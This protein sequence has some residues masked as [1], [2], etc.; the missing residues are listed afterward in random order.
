MVVDEFFVPSTS[1]P[2]TDRKTLT[3][4]RK[5]LPPDAPIPKQNPAYLPKESRVKSEE[6]PKEPKES[7][8]D[9]PKKGKIAQPTSKSKNKKK[10][11]SISPPKAQEP[12]SSST[13]KPK[14]Q[15]LKK[16]GTSQI[17]T[18]TESDDTVLESYAKSEMVEAM[19]GLD[20]LQLTKYF[21][22]VMSPTM[23]TAT[24][25]TPMISKHYSTKKVND[26]PASTLAEDPKRGEN[27]STWKSKCK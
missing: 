26:I 20:K 21:K 16:R 24:L 12:S 2:K 23:G 27:A 19:R 18:E 10:D 9:G 6:S 17:S 1:D 25:K 7:R 22:Q 3:S 4:K 11:D 15:K 13:S 8:D 14:E 5:A